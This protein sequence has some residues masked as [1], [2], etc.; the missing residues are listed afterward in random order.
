MIFEADDKISD[1]L[2]PVKK[3]DEKENETSVDGKLPGIV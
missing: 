2:T 3:D 1:N